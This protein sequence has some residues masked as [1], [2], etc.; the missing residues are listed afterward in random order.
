MGLGQNIGYGA[1]ITQN[2]VN[3]YFNGSFNYSWNGVFIALMGDPTLN[4]L[5][6][7]PPSNLSAVE[8]NGGTL[9]KWNKSGEKVDGYVVYR[10]DQK[11]QE[12]KEIARYCGLGSSTTT[13]TFYWDYCKPTLL[14]PNAG[15]Y[16]YAVRAFRWETTGSGSYQNLSLASMANSNYTANIGDLS[17]I[18]F[19]L[20]PNPTAGIVTASHLPANGQCQVVITNALGQIVQS[21]AGETDDLGSIR[22]KIAEGIH[23][24]VQIGIV[25]NNQQFSNKLI[26]L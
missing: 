20:F 8:S 13:D 6:V 23:G 4:M 26:V 3:D 19:T 15:E 21:V 25:I 16:K 1:R 12:H 22:W 17:R 9:L 14:N 7:Q 18:G 10:I 24:V 5:Y 11:T 2:N